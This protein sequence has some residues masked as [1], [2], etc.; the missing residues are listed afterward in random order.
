[1]IYYS[2]SYYKYSHLNLLCEHMTKAEEKVKLGKN[3]QLWPVIISEVEM[4]EM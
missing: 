2:S 1:M 4:I 3:Y